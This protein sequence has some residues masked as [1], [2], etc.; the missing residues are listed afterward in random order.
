MSMKRNVL[1][2]GLVA[3]ALSSCVTQTPEARIKKQ[4]AAFLALPAKHQELVRRGEICR[5]MKPDAVRLAWGN[6]SRRYSGTKEGK[7]IERWDYLGEQPV[8]TNQMGFGYGNPWMWGP[9]RWGGAWQ[10]FMGPDVT[11]IPYQRATI[12]FK[13]QLVDSWEKL[14][15]NAR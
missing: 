14:Q 7:D 2:L 12:T 13:N 9:G 15:E 5:G 11:Y 4:A 3:V 10:P 6:P 1:F 8:F